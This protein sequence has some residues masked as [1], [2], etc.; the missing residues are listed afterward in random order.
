MNGQPEFIHIWYVGSPGVLVSNLFKSGRCDLIL[1]FY[2]TKFVKQIFD[3]SKTA[4]PIC[5]KI[6]GN[7]PWV[8]ILYGIMGNFVQFFATNLKI[9]S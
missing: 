7:V 2:G 3:F 8:P 4:A 1:R 5:S 6:G 9:F